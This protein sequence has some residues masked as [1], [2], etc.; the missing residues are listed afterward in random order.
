MKNRTNKK[1]LSNMKCPYCGAPVIIRDASEIYKSGKSQGRKLFVCS[2]YPEC[3]AYS[4]VDPYTLQP[5]STLAN[6][7]LRALRK[8]THDC[9]NQ[10]YEKRIMTKNEA[11]RWLSQIIQAPCRE[12]HI[13]RLSEYYCLEVQKKSRQL[14]EGWEKAHSKTERTDTIRQ[15]K[16]EKKHETYKRTAASR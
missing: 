8:E 14:I 16:E 3:D 6:G 9:F 1:D 7:K 5:I 13:G 15:R 4:R 10:I 11:Y 2:R 12:A